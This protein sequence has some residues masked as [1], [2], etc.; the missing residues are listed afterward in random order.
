MLD[1]ALERLNIGDDWGAAVL[2]VLG[3]GDELQARLLGLVVL[4]LVRDWDEEAGLCGALD[5]DADWSGN[6]GLGDD[7]LASLS[8]DGQVDGWVWEGACLG[9]GEEVLDQ[10]GVVVE[11]E[12]GGV[13]SEED[14]AWVRLH[15]KGEHVLLVLDVDLDLLLGLGVV[16]GE[17]VLDLD[18]HPILRAGTE[19]G[20]NDAVAGWVATGGMVQ[21]AEDD[22]GFSNQRNSPCSN[23]V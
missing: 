20:S 14:L 22:L 23:P 17:A 13:P 21:D 6:I 12:T 18:L 16:D 8:G 2:G 4:D 5:V 19:D 3:G 10:G 9:A 15:V 11:L 1:G 7:A